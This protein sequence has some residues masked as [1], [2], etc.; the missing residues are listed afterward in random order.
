MPILKEFV[1]PLVVVRRDWWNVSGGVS[2]YVWAEK[3][4]KNDLS[5]ASV[6]KNLQPAVLV[7]FRVGVAKTDVK[8]LN[9]IFLQP[10][11]RSLVGA[12]I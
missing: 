2:V 11:C 3:P 9:W 4:R 8:V 5:L 12:R 1:R 7:T 10:R 6:S